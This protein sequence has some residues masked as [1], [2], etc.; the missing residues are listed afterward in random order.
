MTPLAI[1]GFEPGQALG[2]AVL[3][4]GFLLLAFLFVFGGRGPK[5]P[6]AA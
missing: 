6:G 5:P 1:P 3:V 2:G 4:L